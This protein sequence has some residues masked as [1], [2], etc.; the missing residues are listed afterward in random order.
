M[1]PS[2]YRREDDDS[3][4]AVLFAQK[5]GVYAKLTFVDLWD[6]SRDART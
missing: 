5:T 3:M 1:Y 2:D 6:E 4:I